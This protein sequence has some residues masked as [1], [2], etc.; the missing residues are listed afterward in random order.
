MLVAPGHPDR[1]VL[2][3]RLSVRGRG[4]MPPLAINTEDERAV[5]LMRAWI[6]AMPTGPAASREWRVADFASDLA[7]TRTASQGRSPEAGKAHFQTLGCLQCHRRDGEGGSVG[8]DLTGIGQR[9]GAGP[10]LES[11]LEPSKVI[12]PEYA[13]TELETRSGQTLVG[14]I[15]SETAQAV[16]LRPVG[17]DDPVTV[18]VSVIRARRLHPV[19]GMPEGMLNSLEKPQVLD[20]LAYLLSA[21]AAGK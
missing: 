2:L 7:G 6:A 10:L 14:R 9:A 4:Q 17:A 16:V 15:E 8:P 11:L 5:A 1:S 19:S 18:P 20:L 3:H 12:A 13:Q 21:G